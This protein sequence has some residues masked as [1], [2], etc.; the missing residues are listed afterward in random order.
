[1]G[2]YEEDN[3]TIATIVPK[4]GVLHREFMAVENKAE[5]L[6]TLLMDLHNIHPGFGK[7]ASLPEKERLRVYFGVQPSDEETRQKL[8]ADLEGMMADA[9]TKQKLFLEAVYVAMFEP[10][11][12]VYAGEEGCPPALI[13]HFV[14]SS[15]AKDVKKMQAGGMAG[16]DLFRSFSDSIAGFLCTYPPEKAASEDW[17]KKIQPLPFVEKVYIDLCADLCTVCTA[18]EIL[19]GSPAD[20][21]LDFMAGYLRNRTNFSRSMHTAF[22][23]WMKADN[24]GVFRKQTGALQ[25]KAG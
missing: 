11:R 23:E 10:Y 12:A 13:R 9:E 18:S 16:P 5:L 4:N 7:Y 6:R 24:L 17:G 8:L 22:F 15:A 2:A 1:M 21:I 20:Y 3:F 19:E 25:R 14:A